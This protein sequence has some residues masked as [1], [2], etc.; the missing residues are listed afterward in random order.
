MLAHL[1]EQDL[2]ETGIDQDDEATPLASTELP[3]HRAI[4]N[5]T[6]AL[7]IVHAHPPH[8]ITLSL[9]D[10]EIVPLDMEGFLLVQRAPV[11]GW[12]KRLKPGELAEEIALALGQHRIVIVY[13]HGT[14]AAG[15]FLEEAYHWTSAVEESCYIRYLLRR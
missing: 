4:Y 12:N 7:A 15:Q 2:V 13:G 9:V 10:K 3:V 5:Q 14:F 1:G 6:S 11:L 8:A